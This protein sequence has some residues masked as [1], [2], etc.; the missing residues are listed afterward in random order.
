MPPVCGGVGEW[1]RAGCVARPSSLEG[2]RIKHLEIPARAEPNRG[3]LS[4]SGRGLEP[5]HRTEGVFFVIPVS[6][7]IEEN[8]R[9]LSGERS[10]SDGNQLCVCALE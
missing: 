1:R 4:E 7:T 9:S 6:Q 3:S 5:V 2:V 8:D 10:V